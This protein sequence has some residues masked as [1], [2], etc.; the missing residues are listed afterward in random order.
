MASWTGLQC[1]TFLRVDKYGL[2]DPDDLKNA[3]TG[4]TCLVSIMAANN[5]TGSIQ[6]VAELARIAREQGALFHTDAVQ[7]AGKIPVDVQA[8]GVDFLTVSGHKFHGPKGTGAVY[9]RKGMELEPLIHGGKQEW[10]LR[11]GTENTPGIVGMGRAASLAVNCLRQMENVRV[12][13]DRLFEGISR[14][15]PGARLN[16]HP[17]ARLPNT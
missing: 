17:E 15:V 2:I 6:P 8:W 5:E 12:F 13:R 4:K 1:A 7:A 9:I 3:V 16:G 11:G 10:G 14:I